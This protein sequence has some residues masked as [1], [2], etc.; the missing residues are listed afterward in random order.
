MSGI[1]REIAGR[2]AEDKDELERAIQNVRKELKHDI[3]SLGRAML[4][5]NCKHGGNKGK[6]R[7]PVATAPSP[8]SSQ[9]SLANKF[10]SRRPR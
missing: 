7:F 3:E 9:D 10:A 1:M 8:T 5:G 6:D 4:P 2:M